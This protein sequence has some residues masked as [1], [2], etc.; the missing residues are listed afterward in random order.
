MLV[1]PPGAEFEGLLILPVAARIDGRVLGQVLAESDVWIGES[2]YVGANLAGDRIVVA[3][4]VEGDVYARTSIELQAT[5][6]VRGSLTAPK[7]QLA[8][9]AV[10]DGACR[11]GRGG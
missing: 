9:G 5:G 4:S 11:S 10:V 8:E 6:R 7:L 2:G 3:G 1:V